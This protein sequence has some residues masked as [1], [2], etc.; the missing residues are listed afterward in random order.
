MR[1][2]K[3][4]RQGRRRGRSDHKCRSRDLP[5]VAPPAF[6]VVRWPPLADPAE[7]LHPAAMKRVVVAA[8][9][10]ALLS[11]GGTDL[12]DDT[13]QNSQGT[14]YTPTQEGLRHVLY[15]H[16]GV[17]STIVA[18]VLWVA[19]PRLEDDSGNPPPGWN[20]NETPGTFRQTGESSAVFI[21]DTGARATFTRAAPGT[22]D[23]GANCE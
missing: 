9:L 13:G 17:V 21:A 6:P 5:Q 11:C 18:A 23:P 14:A 22:A 19:E 16:C 20:E 2:I 7:I 3:R 4:C 10:V 12:P 8:S 15:T 1:P